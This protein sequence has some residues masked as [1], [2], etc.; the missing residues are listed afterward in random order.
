LPA[1]A[2]EMGVYTATP[3][4][5]KKFRDIAIPAAKKFFAQSL[6]EEGT[7]WVEKYLKAVEEAKKAS[8]SK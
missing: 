4:E 3:E 5:L 6:G 7:Q 1:L 8:M 2:A